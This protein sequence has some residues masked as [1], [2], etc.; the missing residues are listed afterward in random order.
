[1]ISRGSLVALAAAVTAVWPGAAGAQSPDEQPVSDEELNQLLEGLPDVPDTDPGE[2]LSETEPPPPDWEPIDGEPPL[3]PQP[4]PPQAPAP[5]PPPP[6]PAPVLPAPPPPGPAPAAPAPAPPAPAPPAPPPPPAAQPIGQ[7]PAPPQ[8]PPAPPVASPLAASPPPRTD[9]RD[10]GRDR[11]RRAADEPERPPADLPSNPA[12]SQTPSPAPPAEVQAVSAPEPV[13][14][15][16]AP[17]AQ[18]PA[19]VEASGR[20]HVVRSGETLWSI[21]AALLGEGASPARIATV[22]A[23]LWS[24][25]ADRIRSGEPDLIMPGDRLMLPVRLD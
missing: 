2:G 15:E 10:E 5:P 11:Q 22:V 25:N 4:P 1:L 23:R 9:N 3:A 8:P 17:T 7:P 24:L 6:A 12:V 18:E 16:P 19:A 21:A 13:A 20:V 14:A